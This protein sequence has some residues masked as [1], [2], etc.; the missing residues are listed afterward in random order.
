MHNMPGQ[1]YMC[2]ITRP[3]IRT[4][5]TYVTYMHAPAYGCVY[6]YYTHARVHVIL[7]ILVHLRNEI[8][9]KSH[10]EITFIVKVPNGIH[11]LCLNPPF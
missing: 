1:S 8:Q 7:R 10:S 9:K 2:I 3:Y 4:L 6:V 5:G 11:P